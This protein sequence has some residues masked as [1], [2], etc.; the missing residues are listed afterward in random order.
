MTDTF[1]S[2]TQSLV[3]HD[4]DESGNDYLL[5]NT[6]QS[7]FDDFTGVTQTQTQTQP[8]DDVIQS[9]NNLVC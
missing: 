9:Q 7:Q 1:Q 2:N 8:F 5:E 3:F 6:Q 4:P